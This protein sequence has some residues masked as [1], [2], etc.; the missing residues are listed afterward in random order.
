MSLL[1]CPNEIILEILG[2]LPGDF[3]G[4]RALVSIG[5]TCKKLGELVNDDSLYIKYKQGLD[6]KFPLE[7]THKETVIKLTGLKRLKDKLGTKETLLELYE[8]VEINLYSMHLEKVPKEINLL[9]N[10]RKLY[11]CYNNLTTLSPEITK[12]INLQNLFVHN[13]QLKELPIGLSN[14]VNLKCL[15]LGNNKLIEIPEDIGLLRNLERL[16]LEHNLLEKIPT[17]IG[18]LFNLTWLTLED[19]RLTEIPKEVAQL[20]KLRLLYLQNNQIKELPKEI[21][22]MTNIGDITLDPYLACNLPPN[23]ANGSYL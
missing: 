11:L 4:M 12:L 22:H 18:N 8:N 9:I 17:T 15:T 7:K 2:K 13:N 10:L 21:T 19:N 3:E 1:E 5:L 20:A 6:A 16:D 14:L 23:F